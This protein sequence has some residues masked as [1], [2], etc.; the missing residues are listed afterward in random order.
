MIIIKKMAKRAKKAKSS[1][2]KTDL[3]VKLLIV[4]FVVCSIIGWAGWTR[5]KKIVVLYNLNGLYPKKAAVVGV[6]DGQRLVLSNGFKV[7]LAG[8]EVPS[9]G[10]IG[11][12]AA[13]DF[14]TVLTEKKE[15]NLEYKIEETNSEYTP[16]YLFV[17]CSEPLRKYCYKGKISVNEVMVDEGLAKK[18][19]S[20]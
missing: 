15:V 19:N 7:K 1:N 8:I 6:I 14:L 10:Y 3:S 11:Y 5:L 9:E 13:K 4:L 20:R 16:V 2:S 12:Q 17:N 18:V